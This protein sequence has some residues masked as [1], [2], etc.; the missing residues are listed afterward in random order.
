MPHEHK[1]RRL[2][3]RYGKLAVGAE[4]LPAQG[5][6]GEK[7]QRVGSGRGAETAG[8]APHPWHNG[9]VIKAHHQLGAQR[10]PP[11]P[12]HDHPHQARILRARRH[13]VD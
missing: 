5:H 1:G 10:H 2:A 4:I 8:H 7:L 9:A 13:A 11:A 6:V 12:A 3:L